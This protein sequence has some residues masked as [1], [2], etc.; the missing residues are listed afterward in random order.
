[1]YKLV[2]LRHG[3][4][5]WNLENRFTGWTDVSLTPKG[6]T[7]ASSAGEILNKYGYKFDIVYTSVLKRAINTMKICLDKMELKDIVK[8]YDWRLNERHYGKL[9]GLD[10]SETAK[11]FGEKQV[12]I[13]RRSYDSSPPAL[14]KKDKRHPRFDKKYLKLKL[15]QIPNSESLKQTEK[16]FMPLWEKAIKTKILSGKNILIVAHGNSLRALVKHL[17]K[18]SNEEILKINIPTGIPLVY[19]LDYQLNSLKNYYLGNEKK[20]KEKISLVEMQ[21]KKH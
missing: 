21:G 7:E 20:I 8:N 9:Q 12:L 3:E 19:E 5:E 10:K 14:E 17:D 16:R 4:S 6:V 13:W 1:M 11:K 18:L 2:L 15:S